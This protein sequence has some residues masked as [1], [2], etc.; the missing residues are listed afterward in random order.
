MVCQKERHP[1]P[2]LGDG[3]KKEEV[4][5]IG[6]NGDELG[7]V[8]GEGGEVEKQGRETETYEE[9]ILWSGGGFESVEEVVLVV[10]R[11]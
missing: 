1:E 4:R 3:K 10:V 6:L 7:V 11:V 5:D 2:M 9:T 8:V